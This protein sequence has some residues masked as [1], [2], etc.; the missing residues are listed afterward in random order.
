MSLLGNFPHTVTRVIRRVVSDKRMG[1][2][3]Q[4]GAGTPLT[5][6][7]QTASQKEIQEFA[8]NG[9]VVTHKIYFTSDP[10]LN[11]ETSI[12]FEGSHFDFVA[13]A[14][15]SAGLGVVFKAFFNERSVRQ[16]R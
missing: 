8:Q 11:E 9:E 13:E 2:I 5:A 16:D 1:T 15:A 3:E 12:D 7:V 10:G 4:D 6:W 14:D